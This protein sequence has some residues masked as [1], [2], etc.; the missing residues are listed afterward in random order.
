MIRFRGLQRLDWYIIRKFLVTFFMAILFLAVIIVI[1]DVSE[2]I[3][4]FVRQEA[5]LR[6]IV[7][8][9]YVNFV[10]FFMNQYSPMFLFLTVIFF[11][12]KMTQDSEVIA[13]LSSGISY[14]RMMVPYLVS[15]VFIG[16]IS[17]SMG[18]WIIPRANGPRVDFEQKYIPRVKAH[19]GQDMHYK[20]ENDHFVYIESFS[21][22]NNTAYNFTLEDLSGGELRSKLSAESAQYDT[23]TGVWRL[24]NWFIRDYSGGLE[25]Q[26][27]SGRQL[28]TVI[29]LT[30]EDFFR[31][32]Y[33]IQR[34]TEPE[35]DRL[36]ETQIQ[37]GDASVSQALIEK[38]NRFALP[39]SAI[40]LTIIGVSLSTKKKRGGM[41]WNIAAGTALGFS[42]I[43]FMQFSEMF[44]VTDTLPASIATWLPNVL[45]TIIAIILYIKAP[46]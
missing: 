27:R 24:R 18:L 9:Y 36:I 25:D 32:R 30:R 10:P 7:F 45:Y 19:A 11:T 12:S 44:V 22:Y 14:H 5:P 8:D 4:D 31:N 29:S 13:I 17:L 39:F 43:L 37:R 16:L 6:E 21:G 28:D 35:L 41:G 23:T 33:T 3:D 38:N 40:I 15:A 20:L 1:F 42:Y 2:K 46:K 26:V 34:L